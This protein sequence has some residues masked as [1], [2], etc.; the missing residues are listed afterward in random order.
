MGDS[1]EELAALL[2]A[3]AESPRRDNT[4]FHK[5]MSEAR[6]AFQDAEDALGGP[7]RV[8]IKTRTKRNGAYIVKWTFTREK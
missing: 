1:G 8:K 6:R 3:V 5:A 2:K 4:A 7:A